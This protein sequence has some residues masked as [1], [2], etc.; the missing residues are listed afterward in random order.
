MADDAPL[1]LFEC[2]F[3]NIAL[4]WQHGLPTVRRTLC[5]HLT[6]MQDKYGIKAA[7]LDAATKDYV[8][9]DG[10]MT[11]A[12]GDHFPTLQPLQTAAAMM[13]L[14][15]SKV[16]TGQSL[17]SSVTTVRPSSR[18]HVPIRLRPTEQSYEERVLDQEA[19]KARKTKIK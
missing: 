18:K 13:Q 5:E 3:D 4:P 19:Y 16:R 1:V 9:A 14:N 2:G 11:K 17:G 7:L 8:D 15:E 6:S 12:A 10:D